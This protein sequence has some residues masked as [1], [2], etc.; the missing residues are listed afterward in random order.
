MRSPA[1]VLAAL[2]S[3]AA[4][5]G[6][7]TGGGEDPAAPLTA[8]E[9]QR[10]FLRVTN[11]RLVVHEWEGLVGR[12]PPADALVSWRV[13]YRKWQRLDTALTQVAGQGAD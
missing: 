1:R 7:C 10:G 12:G 6:G 3:S 4:V 5:V 11:D 2:L 13:A 9:V 8:T